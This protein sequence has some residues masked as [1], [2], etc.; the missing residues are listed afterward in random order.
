MT[1]KN[2]IGINTLKTVAVIDDSEDIA[3]LFCMALGYENYHCHTF[4]SGKEFLAY[5][6]T[7]EMPALIICD[8]VMPG[9]S[10]IELV[11]ILQAHPDYDAVKIIFSSGASNL[12]NQ[13]HELGVDRVLRKPVSL[14]ELIS[15][16]NEQLA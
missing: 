1:N 3:H 9:M 13:A 16:V 5:L 8:L 2:S 7:N 11:R 12:L 6:A 10:G 4:A 15:T 14:D